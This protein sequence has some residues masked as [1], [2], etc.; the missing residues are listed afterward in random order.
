M[1]YYPL[2]IITNIHVEA[3]T[4]T[5]RDNYSEKMKRSGACNTYESSSGARA[6]DEQHIMEKNSPDRRT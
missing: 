6:E 1:N 4:C 2:S 5:E 3:Y